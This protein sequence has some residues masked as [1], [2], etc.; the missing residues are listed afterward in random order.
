VVFDTGVNERKD[1]GDRHADG[2]CHTHGRDM[3]K[4]SWQGDDD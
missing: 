2:G 4:S 1:D 3:V